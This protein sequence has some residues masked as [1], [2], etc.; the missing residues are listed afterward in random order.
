ETGVFDANHP[1]SFVKY[2]RE[3]LAAKLEEIYETLRQQASTALGWRTSRT[4]AEWIRRIVDNAPFNQTDGAWLRYV[5]NAGPNDRV[6]GLLFEVWSDE[7]GNG[8]PALH[9]GN[10]YTTLLNSL[11]KSLPAVSSRAYADYSDLDESKYIA[12]VFQLAISLHSESFFPELLG[13]T[14]FLEWEV[15][16]LVPTIRGLDYIGIDSQ[17]WWM[18]VGIDNASEGHGA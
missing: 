14:L 8:D 7:V 12:P 13:M 1:E 4:H 6:K 5:A 16:S 17:F 11:G 15:L 3:S 18:H 10:L 2:S 9:H